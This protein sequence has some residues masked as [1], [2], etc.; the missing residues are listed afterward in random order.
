MVSV[1]LFNLQPSGLIYCQSCSCRRSIVRL[2]SPSLGVYISPKGINPK[3]NVK[4]RLGFQLANI[5]LIVHYVSYNSMKTPPNLCSYRYLLNITLK[6]MSRSEWVG[7]QQWSKEPNNNI[8]TLPLFKLLVFEDVISVH[9]INIL[10]TVQ[11]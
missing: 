8:V 3:L 9:K 7:C 2:F 11:K 5:N 6:R 10:N 4:V 1:S